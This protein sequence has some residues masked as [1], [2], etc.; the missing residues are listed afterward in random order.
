MSISENLFSAPEANTD[1]TIVNTLNYEINV[2]KIKSTQDKDQI[3]SQ[4]TEIKRLKEREQALNKQ[5][6]QN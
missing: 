4:K 3:E 2:L 1:S 6:K 5:L